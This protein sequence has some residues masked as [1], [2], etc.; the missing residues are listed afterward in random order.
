MKSG[1]SLDENSGK[2]RKMSFDHIN[3]IVD[4]IDH[5]ISD[6]LPNTSFLQFLT[7]A[8]LGSWPYWLYTVFQHTL[9][10]RMH[11]Q[12]SRNHA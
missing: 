9:S 2:M 12:N 6:G 7:L 10:N 4:D 8:M 1:T 3:N 5:R 11:A